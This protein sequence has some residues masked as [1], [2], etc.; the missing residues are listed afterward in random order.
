M[1]NFFAVFILIF[2]TQNTYLIYS[3]Y[4]ERKKQ[5]ESNLLCDATSG[6]LVTMIW[7]KWGLFF[8]L[9][10][11]CIFSGVHHKKSECTTAKVVSKV[12]QILSKAKPFLFPKQL[13]P[14]VVAPP[15]VARKPPKG[16][17]GWGDKR[18]V[19]MCLKLSQS[20]ST[21]QLQQQIDSGIM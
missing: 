10:H 2:D 3:I 15:K 16:N 19:D 18:D 4:N 9:S 14:K 13:V 17:G 7:K 21:M 11:Y 1:N 20:N 12:K 5:V 8:F 6:V